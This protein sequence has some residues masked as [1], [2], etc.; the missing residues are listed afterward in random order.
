MR[1]K[2]VYSYS[3]KICASGFNELLES[4]FFLLMVVEAFSL[5]KLVKML[6]EVV[7]DWQEVRWIWLE[8]AMAPHSSTL[9]W[10]ILG[11]GEPSGLL[12]MGSHRVGHEWSDLAAAAAIRALR[13]VKE[14][15]W[16]PSPELPLIL[17]LKFMIFFYAEWC[18]WWMYSYPLIFF[19]LSLLL[20]AIEGH[21]IFHR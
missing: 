20:F 1:N 8:K 18:Q 2:F 9:A 14:D 10:R 6:E 4:I 3:V 12:S 5:Q 11:T 19:C 21:E 13:S 17:M 16:C 15:S 7:V